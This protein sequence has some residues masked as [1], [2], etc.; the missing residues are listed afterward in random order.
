VFEVYTLEAPDH[1]PYFTRDKAE[2]IGLAGLSIDTF[3]SDH[4]EFVDVCGTEFYAHGAQVGS[5]LGA[6]LGANLQSVICLCVCL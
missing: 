3:S 6:P 5:V 1:L 2:Y 4:D